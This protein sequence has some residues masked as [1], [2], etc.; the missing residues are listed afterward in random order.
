MAEKTK[1][2]YCNVCIEEKNL[3]ELCK[4]SFNIDNHNKE[5]DIFRFCDICEFYIGK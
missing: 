3:E 1:C 5:T 4:S 2:D